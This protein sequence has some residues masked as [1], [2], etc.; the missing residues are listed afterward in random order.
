MKAVFNMSM[1]ALKS[2]PIFALM[3]LWS[4]ETDE[5]ERGAIIKDLISLTE[6]YD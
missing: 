4:E 5:E 6:D 2:K 3:Q 1:L